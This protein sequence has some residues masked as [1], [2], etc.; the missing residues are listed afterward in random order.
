MRAGAWRQILLGKSGEL[1]GCAMAV[2]AILRGESHEA[3]LELGRRIGV[4]YQM[5]DDLLDYCPDADTG[6]EPL[7]DYRATAWTW[8]LAHAPQVTFGLTPREVVPALFGG[9]GSPAARALEQIESET[10]ALSRDIAGALGPGTVLL[11]LLEE[12]R[13]TAR[14]GIS[15]GIERW[16]TERPSATRVPS[17]AH[18]VA[19]AAPKRADWERYMGAHSRSFRFASSVLPPHE[20]KRIAAVY[21]WCRY[22]DDLVDDASSAGE[23]S[24]VLDAWLERS[25]RAYEG[26][27]T[28]IDLLDRVM[29]ET[30]NGGVPFST[31]AELIAGMRMD[32]RHRPYADR[33]G[34]GLYTWRAAGTVGLWLAELYG[35]RDPWALERAATLGQA[36]QLTNILR[37]VGDD[38]DRG[39]VYLPLD[40]LRAHGLSVDDLRQARAAR[41]TPGLAWNMVLEELMEDAAAGYHRSAEA[42]DALPVAFRRAV[43]V[44]SSVYS[45]IHDAIRRNG[46][47]SLNRRATTS[48]VAKVSLGARALLRFGPGRSRARVTGGWARLLAA[49]P[50]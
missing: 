11:P 16:G 43:T 44:A 8:P 2:G 17:A 25:R 29:R 42:L 12:W 6:K 7:A 21:A 35:V 45:G 14:A 38:L 23:A 32:A 40:V 39:R 26:D 3:P 5:Y 36:M 46:Y 28:G 30:R 13:T 1:F 27:V 37:D 31:V 41:T 34:L 33:R 19:A 15:A 24:T 22:T 20:R 48:L 9:A 49:E 18:S 10:D 47:D 4:L 50:A